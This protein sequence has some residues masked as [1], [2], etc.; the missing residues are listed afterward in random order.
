M[1]AAVAIGLLW[2]VLVAWY[3]ISG[4]FRPNIF[5]VH[6]PAGTGK[7]RAGDLVH[8]G[9]IITLGANLRSTGAIRLLDLDFP[10]L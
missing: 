8:I 10:A 2:W 5:P 4:L 9:I 1:A 7:V 6:C 3:F